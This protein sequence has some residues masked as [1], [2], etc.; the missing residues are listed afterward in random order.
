[1]VNT[2]LKKPGRTEPPDFDA[3]LSVSSLSASYDK[4]QILSDINL[5]V[6]EGQT[7]ALLG[8]SGCGKTTLLR[9]IAGL[10]TPNTGEVMLGHKTLFGPKTNILPEHRQI[11]MVFQD[12]ALFPHLSVGRNVGYGLFGTPPGEKQEFIQEALSLVGLD[13][14]QTR[15]IN[16]LSGGQKQRVALSR[17]LAP[18]P[19]VLLL[20]EPFASL[21]AP[22][23]VSLRGQ[24]HELLASLQ[25]TAIFVTHDQDEAFILGDSV[26][27]MSAA[28]T[29]EQ[30]DSPTNIYCQPATPWVADF[31]GSANLISAKV[32]GSTAH[33]Q[34]GNIPLALKFKDQQKIKVVVRPE[35]L[36]I[37]PGSEAIVELV[38]YYGH[39][40]MYFLKDRQ[41]TAIWARSAGDTPKFTRGDTVKLTYMGPPA[42]A[43][44]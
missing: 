16:T 27:V 22:T 25:T 23:R 7:L 40:V 31:V 15:K 3:T 34:M 24:V 1:M 12:S 35:H 33:T 41:D 43:F 42:V 13:G 4:T 9:A 28:G 26:G 2:L 44:G 30:L 5:E 11:G 18:K 14:Y 39:D 32:Q 20:D 8:P 29:I 19:K 10:E 38:E 21:D 37:S 17:A 36:E 6:T